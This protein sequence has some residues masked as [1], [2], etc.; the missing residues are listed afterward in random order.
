MGWG[1]GGGSKI[2]TLPKS[3]EKSIFLK[4]KF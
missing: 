1:G 3:P 2:S 4:L